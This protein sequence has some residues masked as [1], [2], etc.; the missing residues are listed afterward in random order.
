MLTATTVDEEMR[1]AASMASLALAILV[2]FTNVRREAL[3]KHLADVDAINLKTVVDALP[4]IALAF[5]TGAA[6]LVMAPLSFDTFDFGKVGHR[7]GA[8]PSMFGL[9]WLG[10]VLV[11]LFQLSMLGRRLM[12]AIKAR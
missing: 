9:I 7:S 2:F 10:F 4:D 12:Q 3:T 5:L 11:L 6:I 8:V 1:A